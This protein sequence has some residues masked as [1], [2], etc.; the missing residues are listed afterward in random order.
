MPAPRSAYIVQPQ[1]AGLVRRHCF[2]RLPLVTPEEHVS[3]DYPI[4]SGFPTMALRVLPDDRLSF[5]LFPV[6]RPEFFDAVVTDDAGRVLEIQVKAARPESQLGLGRV[7]DAGARPSR[8]AR[9]LE[10]ASR[11]GRILRNAGERISRRRRPA[12]RASSAGSDYVD[13]GTVDGYRAA[14]QMLEP[15]ERG[16]GATLARFPLCRKAPGKCRSRTVSTQ[17]LDRDRTGERIRALGTWFHNIDLNG[18]IDRAGPFLGDYP[19][20]KWRRFA[21]RDSGRSDRQ[22]G[23]RHRLQRAA[24][25]RSR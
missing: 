9:A 11:D 13:V 25:T 6:D 1:A 14:M 12:R 2:V 22:V 17:V 3:L 24:S 10:S 19:A 21:A 15:D 16:C 18:V 5:L 7:Q 23:A 8:A 4:P 20:I